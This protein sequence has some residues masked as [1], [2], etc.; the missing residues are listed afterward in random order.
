MA[1]Y[2]RKARS[3]IARLKVRFK[4]SRPTPRRVASLRSACSAVSM[5]PGSSGTLSKE[6][7]E[8]YKGQA[9]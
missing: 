1:S 5:A 9:D 6:Q 7:A 2:W 4:A 3:S 8:E